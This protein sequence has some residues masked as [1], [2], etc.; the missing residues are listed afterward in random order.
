M[1]NTVNN[2]CA[3]QT[4]MIS[5]P[6]LLAKFS[7]NSSISSVFLEKVLIPSLRT[8][9][10]LKQE[11][12]KIQL[13]RL[14]LS[15]IVSQTCPRN[16]VLIFVRANKSFHLGRDRRKNKP[17]YQ[18][19]RCSVLCL[20][21]LCFQIQPQFKWIPLSFPKSYFKKCA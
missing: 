20:T 7:S 12:Y 14:R 9:K 10:T 16:F 15:C 6:Q 3:T 11:K 19:R 2:Q 4:C 18:Q 5:V 13:D 21:A 17:V 1:C 8:S